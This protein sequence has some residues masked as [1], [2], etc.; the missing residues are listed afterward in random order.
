MGGRVADAGRSSAVGVCERSFRRFKPLRSD[1]YGLT[2][3]GNHSAEWPVTRQLRGAYPPT[4][5]P[6]H[7]SSVQLPFGL[8][9]QV[10]TY[11]LAMA[12]ESR[13]SVV[14]ISTSPVSSFALQSPQDPIRQP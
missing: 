10:R 1:L 5:R 2:S 9:T 12:T 7:A 14:D 4:G 8:A 3:R 6:H 13:P 11:P